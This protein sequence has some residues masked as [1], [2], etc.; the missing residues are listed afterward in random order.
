MEICYAMFDKNIKHIKQKKNNGFLNS[1]QLRVGLFN[2]SVITKRRATAIHF[3]VTRDIAK[4]EIF[5]NDYSDVGEVC[6]ET[7]C[8][9]YLIS[10]ISL[11]YK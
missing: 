8:I 6:V 3:K 11:Q 2:I 9:T 7:K 1:S 5:F 10:S 4:I